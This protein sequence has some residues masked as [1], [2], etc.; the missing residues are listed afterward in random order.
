MEIAGRRL[1]ERLLRCHIAFAP[2]GALQL[3][4]FF[5]ALSFYYA[6]YMAHVMSR[7]LNGGKTMLD[8]SLD[9][10]RAHESEERKRILQG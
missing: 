6:L 4:P 9:K 8:V 5:T 1:N 2:H 10:Y 7:I 3:P